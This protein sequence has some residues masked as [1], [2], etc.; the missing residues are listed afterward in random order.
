MRSPNSR[1]LELVIMRIKTM[2]ASLA[3]TVLLAG[4]GGAVGE[5][6]TRLTPTQ[7]VTVSDAATDVMMLPPYMCSG[8]I[9]A[10]DCSKPFKLGP[11]G[12]VTDFSNREWNSGS[13]KWCDASGM[14][15]STFSFKGNGAM[16]ANSVAVNMD[17]SLRLT[18]TVSAGSYG[19]GGLAFEA[20]CLDASEFTG[21][22]FSVAVASGD[23]TG[24]TYQLQ[25]Q[26]FE[27][28]P[29][30]Q[31]PAGGCDQNTTSCYSYPA[32][33]GLPAPSA[34][35]TMPTVVSIPFGSFGRSMMPAPAQIVGLQWQVNSSG[36]ACTVELRLDDIGFIPAA[37]T[38][39]PGT[40]GGT[41]QD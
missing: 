36:G 13:G 2:A 11:D 31:S 28:R 1:G 7:G 23:L 9:A 30:S 35:I 24:C 21:V 10:L 34:D 14:H 25:L 37:G 29:T 32:A 6:R 17:G 39:E 26:T 27:Q 20:G 33:T 4:C 41:A 16:D 40:D 22:T 19:G 15:G 38:P 18:L 5:R 3:M 8:S 12:H